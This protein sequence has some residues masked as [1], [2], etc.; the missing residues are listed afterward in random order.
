MEQDFEPIQSYLEDKLGIPVKVI[1]T[2]NYAGL[3]EGMKNETLDIAWNGAF[4]Y[5][6]C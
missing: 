3:I 4:S 2:E 5:D 6:I 1:I